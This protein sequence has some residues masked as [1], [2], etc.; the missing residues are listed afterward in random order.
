VWGFGCRV[1]GLGLRV[2]G[3]RQVLR[4]NFMGREVQYNRKT[5][6]EVDCTNSSPFLIKIVLCNKL[7]C[8]KVFS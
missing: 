3:L 7:H 1:E 5:G 4:R 8:Q 2:W 6:D